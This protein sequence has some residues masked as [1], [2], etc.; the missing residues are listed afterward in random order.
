MLTWP[1][2]GPR[3]GGESSQC[4][5]CPGTEPVLHFTKEQ[6]SNSSQ[7][8]SPLPTT[9][10]SQ[11]TDCKFEAECLSQQMRCAFLIGCG[12]ISPRALLPSSCLINPVVKLFI[13]MQLALTSK[14][15]SGVGQQLVMNGKRLG[16]MHALPTHRL[17]SLSSCPRQQS[18][19]TAST[20]R[21]CFRCCLLS[22][23]Q[24]H[25]VGTAPFQTARSWNQQQ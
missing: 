4:L 15:S 17:S 5:H 21:D 2:L 1:R 14:G 11:N 20:D 25:S 16:E 8:G 22:R 6:S 9:T 10:M 23:E 18:V 13:C 7:R 12:D 24:S 19:A 3:E